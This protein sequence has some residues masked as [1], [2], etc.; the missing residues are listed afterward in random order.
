MVVYDPAY[1][2]VSFLSVL[3]YGWQNVPGTPGKM[4][5]TFKPIKSGAAL[6]VFG[7]ARP[8]DT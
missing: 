3:H 7:V 4:V 6:F 8:S 5:F 1:F 2:L